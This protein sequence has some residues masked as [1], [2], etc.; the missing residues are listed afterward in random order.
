MLT[1]VFKSGNSLAFRIPKE[2]HFAD[3]G[4]YLKVDQVG[5]TLVF[6]PVA[7]ESLANIGDI[8]AKFSPTFMENSRES[9]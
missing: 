8:L 9:N 6:R 7:Q 4:Q 3:V 2:L 5:N 1:R